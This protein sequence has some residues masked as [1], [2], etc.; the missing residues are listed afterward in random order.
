V[1]SA[2]ADRPQ[3]ALTIAETAARLHVSTASVYRL[4]R[5]GKLPGA[6]RVGR[7]WRIDSRRLDAM[8]A[9]PEA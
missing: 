9:E 4:A 5:R 1:E 2:S 8:F 3:E 7:S 6:A